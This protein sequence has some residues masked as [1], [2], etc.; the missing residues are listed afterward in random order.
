VPDGVATVPLASVSFDDVEAY[1]RDVFG[2]PRTGFLQHWLAV[3]GGYGLAVVGEDGGLRG[4]AFLRPCLKGYKFGPVF[5]DDAATARAL[6]RDLMARVPGETV[7]LDVPEPNVEAMAIAQELGWERPFAC[8]K[9]FHG[10]SPPDT[11]SRV[12][13]VTSFEFG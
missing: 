10:A 3:N 9:M 1:D 13:G 2:R 4:Y 8:A 11:T 12:F 6:L 7:A 5:A